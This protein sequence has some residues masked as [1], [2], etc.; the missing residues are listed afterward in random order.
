MKEKN[1]YNSLLLGTN[2]YGSGN[3][4]IIEIKQILVHPKYKSGTPYF[5]AALVEAVEDIEFNDDIR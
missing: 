1:Y 3:G 2:D 5:D 4:K